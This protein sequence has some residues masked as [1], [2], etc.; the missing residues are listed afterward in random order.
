MPVTLRQLRYFQAVVERGT[1]SS[2]AESAHVSQ[3]ALSLQIH[4]LE[5]VLGGTLFER[6]AR[7]AVL[8]PFGR[9]AH[10]QALRVLDE[11]LLLEAMA[12]HPAAGELRITL[13]IVSTLAPYLLPGLLGR[14]RA[15]TPRVAI[16]AVEDR[17]EPLVAALLAGHL[18]A[19][20]V[21]LPLGWLELPE[22]E[23]FEDRFVLAAGPGRSR[24]LGRAMR[25]PDL[26]RSDLGPLLALA[27]GHCLGHQVLGA[28]SRWRLRG[29]HRGAGSVAA[30]SRLV[31]AGDGLTLLPET[32]ALCERAATPGLELLRFSEPEPGRRIGLAHRAAAVSEDWVDLLAVAAAAAGQDLI[33]RAREEI[34]A[35]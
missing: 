34:P 3:P 26:A 4:Q 23:L 31:A 27:D 16:D 8:T 35:G 32:A 6:L 19:A 28:C 5:A 33:C 12:A 30:V 11:T 7:G 22:R 24:A 15:S 20:I 21:S 2:A 29:V 13:G 17:G 10:H 9:T 1:F 25:P 18:D 14:L